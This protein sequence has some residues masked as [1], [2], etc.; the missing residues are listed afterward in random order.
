MVTTARQSEENH[1]PFVLKWFFEKLLDISHAYSS[2]PNNGRG[3]QCDDDL[4]VQVRCC[5]IICHTAPFDQELTAFKALFDKK[6]YGKL[7]FYGSE[8]CHQS[9]EVQPNP[10][11]HSLLSLSTSPIPSSTAEHVIS[12]NIYCKNTAIKTKLLDLQLCSN[13]AQGQKESTFIQKFS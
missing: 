2:L 8:S 1:L 7:L 5:N 4:V 11:S 13:W 9:K 6:L 10:I 12:C 3:N